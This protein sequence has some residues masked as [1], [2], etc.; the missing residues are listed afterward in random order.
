MSDEQQHDRDELHDGQRGGERQV[1]QLRGLA[2]DLGLER[3]ETGPPRIR[4]TPNDVKREQEHDRG[5][6]R[7]RGPERG[8]RHLAERTPPAGAEHP[9]R[10]LLARVE[11]CPEPADGAHDDRVVEED[12]REQDRPDGLVE[13]EVGERAAGA[14]QRG[15]RGPTTTVGSTNGTVTSARTTR[16][17][18]NS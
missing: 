18:G 4:I 16:R 11:V 13:P 10:F 15:E 2:V 3:R 17:P 1:Q 9:R 14:E 8:Q 12:V 6:R 7:D 5:S